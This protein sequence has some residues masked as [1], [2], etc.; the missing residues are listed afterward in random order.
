M[1][2]LNPAYIFLLL[3][4]STVQV[5]G[6]FSICSWNLQDFGQSKSDAEINCIADLIKGYD[7]IAIQ[8]VVAGPGGP[9]AVARL[10]DQLNRKGSK[11]DYVISDPTSSSAYKQ[12]RYAFI[13]KTSR[14]IKKGDTWLEKKYHLEIDREPFFLTIQYNGKLLTLVNFHA[15]TKKRQPETEVKFFKFL[16]ISYPALNLFFVGDFN[17]PQTHSVFNPLKSMGYHPVLT[18]QKTT[19]R[20]KCID[21]DCLASEFDNMFFNKQKVKVVRAGII[22]FFEKMTSLQ[23]AHK[24]SDHVPI[25][26]EIVLN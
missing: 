18:G 26:A 15:I 9:Q 13:W 10:A 6:Q 11:W 3:L 22:P 4:L 2:K 14:V 23:E 1:D 17:L 5:F 19:L 12:E 25:F 8:E 7:V 21:G 24:I 20:T 16:P